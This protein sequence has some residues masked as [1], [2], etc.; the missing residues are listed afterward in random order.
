MNRLMVFGII[1]ENK[2]KVSLLYATHTIS[3][4]GFTSHVNI[5]AEYIN[6]SQHKTEAKFVFPVE[7]DSAVY[8][9][10]AKIG[11]VHLVA[12]SKDKD[13][14]KKEYKQAVDKGQSA[15]LLR[16]TSTSG[17]IF[18]YS[19]GNIPANEKIRLQICLVSELSCEVD[20]A[21]KFH[22]PFV[23]NPRYGLK[24]ADE[25]YQNAPKPKEFSFNAS[26]NWNSQIKDIKSEHPVN[27]EYQDNK[28]H[29]TVRMAKEFNFEKDL[30]LQVYYEDVEKPQVIL[31]K[32]DEN[33]KGMFSKDI[34]MINVFPELP[35]VKQTAA[36]DYIFVIDRSGSMSGEKIEAAKDT[37]LLFLKSLPLGCSFNVISFNNDFEFLFK[38]GS[39]EYSEDSLNEALKFQ[40]NLFASGGTEILSAL[41]SL[42]VKKPFQNFHRQAFLITDGEVY[43]TNDVIQLVKSQVNNTRYFT[44]GIGSGAS[45]ELVKGIARAGKGQAEFVMTNDNLKA[46]VMRLLKLSMQPFVSSVCLSAKHGEN[47][48]ELSFISV[49]ERLPCIFSEEKLILYLVL[50]EAE[51]SCKNVKLNLCGKIGETDFSLDFEASLLGQNN[52]EDNTPSLCEKKI[53]ELELNEDLGKGDEIKSEIIDLGTMANLVSKYTSFVGL[54]EHVRLDFQMASLVAPTRSAM[55]GYVSSSRIKAFGVKKHVPEFMKRR[56]MPMM[57][58]AS[59]QAYNQNSVVAE[60]VDDI[61]DELEDDSDDGDSFGA[62]S[63]DSSC[64]PPPFKV[65]RVTDEESFMSSGSTN[66]DILT[67]LV[68]LQ[69]FSGFWNLDDQLAQALSI[70]LKDLNKE[71]PSISDKVWATALVVAV[72]REKLASQH[73][74]WELMEK[75]AIEWLE[76]QNIQPMNSEKLLEKATNFIKNKMVA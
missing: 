30:L 18:E 34:M 63:V 6:E 17:D 41:K 71:N 13:V 57:C 42:S 44:I 36:N 52:K 64:M 32:G 31:E 51:T 75:K 69:A 59:P 22:M 24:P 11:D 28:C 4:N 48:K 76:S 37:L 70:S 38:E 14:A 55:C 68:G 10:E 5:E 50:H 45:T 49:P 74:E 47:N 40:K 25:N 7:E 19:L 66:K 27:V 43:N 56:C 9:F 3:I 53:Q 1:C 35:Q 67:C 26:V 72:L 39:R 46:K 23:L 33:S 21:V 60:R 8:K 15:I 20:G 16:E 29:A 2:T 54:D 65:R 61:D 62:D 12:K 58:L 73:C